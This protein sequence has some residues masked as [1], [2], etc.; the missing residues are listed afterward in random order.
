MTGATYVVCNGAP[1]PPAGLVPTAQDYVLLTAMENTPN[2]TK[3][4]FWDGTAY[5]ANG[6]FGPNMT[7]L[8]YMLGS[9]Q[10]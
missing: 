5:T 6:V 8:N 7:S 2:A 9:G 10:N 3:V 4:T 1:T